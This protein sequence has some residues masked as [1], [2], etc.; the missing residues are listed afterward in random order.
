MSIVFSHS[1]KRLFS[2][3]ILIIAPFA[4]L[5]ALVVPS[6][7]DERPN[8]STIVFPDSNIHYGRDVDALFTQTCLGSQCHS[9]SSPAKGL[10]LTPPSYDNLMNHVPR[11]V[12]SGTTSNNLLIQRLDGTIPPRMPSNQNPLTDN[13][14]NGIKTWIKEGAK[15]N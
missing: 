10:D 6:C 5:A 8:V 2:Q 14:I 1:H 11:L 9:G 7:K 12:V 3:I 13:Q 4:I 15:N